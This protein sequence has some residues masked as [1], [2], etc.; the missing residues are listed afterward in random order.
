MSRASTRRRDPASI[1]AALGD[2]TRLELVARLGD[3]KHRSIT[4][5]TEG[6]DISRQAVAK[7][8]EVLRGVGV[9]DRQRVGRE[10]RF[11]MTSGPIAEA[12][13]FLARVSDQ[14]DQAIARLREEVES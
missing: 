7:H 9:V 3:G 8:L 1:F 11:Y 13:D 5:L 10:S 6:L 14:W 12:R 4:E 2:V